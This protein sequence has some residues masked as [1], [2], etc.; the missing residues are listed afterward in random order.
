MAK[1]VKNPIEIEAIQF[2]GENH[3]EIINFTEGKVELKTKSSSDTSLYIHTLEGEMQAIPSDWI[4]KG[5]HGEFYPC[6][7]AIFQKTYSEVV[8]DKVTDSG[9][10]LETPENLKVLLKLNEAIENLKQSVPP[11]IV[12]DE[13]K[14]T[15]Y[16]SGLNNAL[17]LS[18]RLLENGGEFPIIANFKKP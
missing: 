18:H 1:F 8:E 4:I 13:A 15:A 5:V 17:F 9:S 6:K 11:N 12:V 3:E 16:L 7:E 10:F 2:T 14:T